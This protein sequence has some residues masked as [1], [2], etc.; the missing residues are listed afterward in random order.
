MSGSSR[1]G[2]VAAGLALVIAWM[3]A[4]SVPLYDGVGFPDE[5]YR[6][7]Q[8]PPGAQGRKAPTSAVGHVTALRGVSNDFFDA[9]SAEQGPQVEIY[10][11]AGALRGAPGVTGFQV[12]A[13]PAA[14]VGSGVGGVSVDGNVYRVQ[15]GSTPPGTVTLA[16]VT[17]QVWAWVALRATSSSPHGPSIVYRAADTG[18][19]KV[20]HTEQT[21]NDVFAANVV[22][23]G[24]Y[25]LAYLKRGTGAAGSRGGGGGVPL[26][27]IV[28]GGTLLLI[29]V[30]VGGIRL[31]R[32]RGRS[33]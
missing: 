2:L 8:P 19:W 28:L 11:S 18:P 7:V 5:P 12:R 6:Y 14:P 25:A 4:P 24:N 16:P 10:A 15:L 23:S 30:A 27:V 17:A 26:T 20:L 13:D 22:G 29:V 21:G 33:T 3:G 31:A 9:P 32:V 1:W